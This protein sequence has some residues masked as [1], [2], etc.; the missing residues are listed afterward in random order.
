MFPCINVFTN[1]LFEYLHFSNSILIL[2]LTWITF[3]EIIEMKGEQFS[4]RQLV[5][6]PLNAKSNVGNLSP[7]MGGAR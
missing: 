6:C 7:I 5:L 3:A 4:L 2:I 1:F